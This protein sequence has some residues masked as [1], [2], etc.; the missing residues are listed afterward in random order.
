[1]SSSH[2]SN[3]EHHHAV[4]QRQHQHH[5]QQVPPIPTAQQQQQQRFQQYQF[6]QQQLPYQQ[7]HQQHHPT[8]PQQRYYHAD[9]AP[10][11]AASTSSTTTNGAP[12][13]S[14]PSL[15]KC[16]Q[17]VY[18]AIAKACEIA[19]R[20][21]STAPL[22]DGG[23]GDGAAV[24]R[25]PG[26]AGGC[27]YGR[28][29]GASA[30]GGGGARG[31]SWNYRG[32][33]NAAS[34]GGDGGE[35]PGGGGG[36][37][38]GGGSGGSSGRFN[39]E[40]EEVRSV[41]GSGELSAWR[42]HAA[43]RRQQ[44]RQRG[45][46]VPLRLDV[47]YEHHEPGR[48]RE[49]GPPQRELLERWCVDYLVPSQPY[50]PSPHSS[51][52]SSPRSSRIVVGAH[53][54]DPP[55]GGG[56]GGGT[57]TSQL[58][59]ACKRIV[60]LLR[61]V[62][63]ATRMLP[64]YRLRCLLLSSERDCH[65]RDAAAAMMMTEMKNGG[66]AA[67]AAASTGG[68][69][70]TAGWGGGWGIIGHT[71]HVGDA[72][73]PPGS[74]PL[75]SSSLP[76]PSFALQPFPCVPTPGGGRLSVSVMY[77][78]TLDPHRMMDDI[79]ERRGAWPWPPQRHPTEQQQHQWHYDDS[80]RCGAIRPSTGSYPADAAG[81]GATMTTAMPA[82][83]APGYSMPIP[84][85][86][87]HPA[88]G[89]RHP[90]YY[91][92]MD[93]DVG[94]GGGGDA[95]YSGGANVNGM[96]CSGGGSLG[97]MAH[98]SCPPSTAPLSSSFGRRPRAV[99][100]FII[101]DYQSSS[102]RLR[103]IRGNSVHDA[104]GMIA[105]AGGA[106]GGGG[107]SKRVM[108]GLSLVMMNQED[109]INDIVK[110]HG[111]VG[112]EQQHSHPP[113]PPT[114]DECAD[115]HHEGLSVLPFG[116]PAARRAAFHT[117]PPMLT[118]D[119][120]RDENSHELQQ[121]S[122]S[123][124]G[125]E[126]GGHF[127]YRHGGY[128][129]GYNN[130][131]NVQFG[132]E[133]PRPPTPPPP[134]QP[135]QTK[136]DSGG[137]G[138]G[139]HGPSDVYVNA[140]RAGSAGSLTRPMST[141]PPLPTMTSRSRSGS[142]SRSVSVGTP[143]TPAL[144]SGSRHPHNPLLLSG[145]AKIASL[146]ESKSGGIDAQQRS[147][148]KH[149]RSTSSSSSV[150]QLSALLPPITSLDV[151]QKSPF[152][153]GRKSAS[154]SETVKDESKHRSFGGPILG[155]QHRPHQDEM[156]VFLNSIPRMV[157]SSSS[158]DERNISSIG[159]VPTFCGDGSCNNPTMPSGIGDNK[160]NAVACRSP[161]VL[162]TES[163]NL[164]FAAD[165]D[166]APL[167]RK[168]AAAGTSMVTTSPILPPKSLIASRSLWGSTLDGTSGGVGVGGMA[169]IA[170]SLAV[171]SLHHR[172]ATDGNIRLKMFEGGSN[173]SRA[174]EVFGSAVAGGG[175]AAGKSSH[176]TSSLARSSSSGVTKYA[177]GGGDPSPD[178]ASIQDQLS[179][180]RSFGASLM[181]GSARHEESL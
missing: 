64:A 8:I 27:N 40:V 29:G 25:A 113:P 123:C 42:G 110:D 122:R 129:Y 176:G 41:R 175:A 161:S 144:L 56:G 166:D 111:S 171:S 100:D 181:A 20:S 162:Q 66:F 55:T 151:L 50:P 11:A 107:N 160:N 138:A 99:S 47:Y 59:Q 177:D 7:Q 95:N 34:G 150:A 70:G 43:R 154:T 146:V 165:D 159:A 81:G 71:I 76:S 172:C 108:S 26:R 117:P 72:T 18:E 132:E 85:A 4:A 120:E 145:S 147:T 65:H 168:V 128:G 67:S 89:G 69:A 52:K 19:V 63:C 36:G 14:A 37:V 104:G 114:A 126:G 3:Q 157:P 170:T 9:V 94:R 78:A 46:V 91:G 164:P 48:W 33:R 106:E 142:I 54:S 137:V 103:P 93:S 80:R 102:P 135:E 143:P 5:S 130:G 101:S 82:G 61:S 57:T 39:I 38:S 127:F 28:G 133:R 30:A 44:R 116:S 21:R 49:G 119:E 178:F 131:S 98:R 139:P 77:D 35:P 136:T 16:D 90:Q 88:V 167:S 84:I 169:E 75:F 118:P 173:S 51:P 6:Q 2:Y 121:R 53:P 180:F 152:A 32:G 174:G 13:A 73:S 1:M 23:G 22:D 125:G 92:T 105:G 163:E 140:S 156:A 149:Y 158:I 86:S 15:S 10:P 109:R 74:D 112:A 153:I 12:S 115:E 60:V 141:T 124:S 45:A 68:G 179:N 87:Q 58:R 31:F 134:L 24:G 83:A 79:A 97:I 17:V 155:S 62:H 96:P 148:Y